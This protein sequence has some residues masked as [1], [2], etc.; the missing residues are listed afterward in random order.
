MRACMRVFS[1]ACA[2][3]LAAHVAETHRLGALDVE[4]VEDDAFIGPE[5]A[6]EADVGQ[7][8]VG[9]LPGRPRH[10]YPDHLRHAPSVLSDVLLSLGP[11]NS[12]CNDGT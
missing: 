10:A 4:Q 12:G 3:T 11:R 5:G 2:C 8:R 9:N 6:S 7:Q 1:G